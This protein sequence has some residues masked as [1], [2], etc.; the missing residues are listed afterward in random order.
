MGVPELTEREPRSCVV[1]WESEESGH[2][3]TI[4]TYKEAIEKCKTMR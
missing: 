3:T 4:R 1:C 2:A